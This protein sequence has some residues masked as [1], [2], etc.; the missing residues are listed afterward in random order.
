MFKGSAS[1]EFLM[2]LL[3]VVSTDLIFSYAKHRRVKYLLVFTSN[4]RCLYPLFRRT[5]L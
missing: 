3:E 2:R 4:F 5:S 1:Y